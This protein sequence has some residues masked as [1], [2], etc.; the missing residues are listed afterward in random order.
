MHSGYYLNTLLF[1]GL[2]DLLTF[3]GYV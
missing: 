3:F 2:A 1:R